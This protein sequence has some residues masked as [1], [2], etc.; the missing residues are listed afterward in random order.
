MFVWNGLTQMTAK[1]ADLYR[2]G[3]AALSWRQRAELLQGGEGLDKLSAA[4]LRRLV[5][6][7]RVGLERAR[8]AL[9]YFEPAA[10]ASE[11]PDG[12]KEASG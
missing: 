5:Q 11:D 4:E 12:L 10:L 7:Q 1:S 9:S 6:L 3:E 8:N 2:M